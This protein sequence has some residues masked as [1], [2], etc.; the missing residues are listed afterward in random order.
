MNITDGIIRCR[1]RDSWSEPQ[2]MVPGQCVKVTIKPFATC[3]RFA[4]GHRLRVDIASSNFPHFDVN[5][6]S[7]EPEGMADGKRVAR[8]VLHMSR[9]R[10]SRV[11]L[12]V[13]PR[14]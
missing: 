3:N 11:V 10:P 6:N 1:Y 8:N 9:L 7:G 4:K 2:P 13:L 12:T 5:P 14:G